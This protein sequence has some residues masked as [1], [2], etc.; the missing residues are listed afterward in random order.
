MAL[1]RILS[2]AELP[3]GE[4]RRVEIAGRTLAVFNVDGAFYALDNAC[5]HD[6]GP[7][8]EGVVAF[9]ISPADKPIAVLIPPKLAGDY[10]VKGRS[11]RASISVPEDGLLAANKLIR[12]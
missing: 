12:N 6:D 8:S 10:F 3:P 9:R 11:Y 4:A 5:T 2:T 7:L 1:H